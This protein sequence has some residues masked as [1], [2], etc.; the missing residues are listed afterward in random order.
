VIFHTVT[1]TCGWQYGPASKKTIKEMLHLHKEI[2]RL[3][4]MV[5]DGSDTESDR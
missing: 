5:N 1:C 4:A 3:E 2:H